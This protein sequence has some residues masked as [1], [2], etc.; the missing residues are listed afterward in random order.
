VDF[1]DVS[2]V[3]RERLP[4][5]AGGY[6]VYARITGKPGNDGKPTLTFNEGELDHLR[7]GRPQGEGAYVVQLRYYPVK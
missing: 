1:A 6:A 3:V 5:N 4:A 2:D 7:Q